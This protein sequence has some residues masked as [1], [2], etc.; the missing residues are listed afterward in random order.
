[1]YMHIY[2]YMQIDAGPGQEPSRE[3]WIDMEEM[4]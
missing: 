2:V 3:V 4:E 1:M